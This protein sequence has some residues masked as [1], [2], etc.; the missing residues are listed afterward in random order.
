M[1]RLTSLVLGLPFCYI[2]N[3]RKP[4]RIRAVKE[5][6]TIEMSFI[7]AVMR[8]NGCLVL[9]YITPVTEN[10]TISSHS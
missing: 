10:F 8:S 6:F 4:H 1:T 9:E 2:S 3:Q 7:K 5:I